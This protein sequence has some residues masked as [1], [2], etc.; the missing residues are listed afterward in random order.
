MPDRTVYPEV[1]KMPSVMRLA[2]EAARCNG[3]PDKLT[4][5]CFSSLKRNV[6][7]ANR[8]QLWNRQRSSESLPPYTTS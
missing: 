6:G 8:R 2:F 4:K 3:V 7:I 1:T 5:R